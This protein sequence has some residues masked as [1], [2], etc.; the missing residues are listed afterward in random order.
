[1]KHLLLAAALLPVA[2]SA[3]P[4]SPQDRIAL[5]S[6][7]RAADE[8][9]NA[10]D[11]KA[12]SLHY[13]KDANLRLGGMAEPVRGRDS[14]RAYF[15]TAFAARQGTL[16]HVTIVDS[17]EMPRPGL[18]VSDAK[19]VVEARTA[20]GS[21]KPVREFTNTSVAIREDGAWKLAAVRAT[22]LPLEQA[23]GR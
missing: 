3:A 2:A 11:A 6:L 9:W 20:D 10:R 1:M 19:V 5:Q 12:M 17:I 15:E 8:A 23:A 4:A 18:A 16:R 13:A 21:W 14:V 22:P 7:A